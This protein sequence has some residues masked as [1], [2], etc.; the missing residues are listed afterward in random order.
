MIS[1]ASL[2]DIIS[3]TKNLKVLYVEDNE[4]A[5]IQAIKLFNN[6]FESIDVAVDGENGLEYYKNNILETNNYYDLIITDIQ[7]PNLNG[8]DSQ[9]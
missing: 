8:I 2:L 4:E 9:S 6:F 1:K 3:I 5:R 7:M